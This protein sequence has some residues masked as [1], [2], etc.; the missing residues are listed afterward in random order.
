MNLRLAEE[1]EI[2][3]RR[4]YPLLYLVKKPDSREEKENIVHSNSGLFYIFIIVILFTCLGIL[5]NIGLKIQGINYQK[6]IYEINEMISLEE[7]RS[8]RLLLKISELKS[9]SRIIEAAKND[10]NMDMAGDFKIVEISDSGLENSEKIYN[11]ISKNT[12][13]V[14]KNYDSFLG[15]IYYIQ[16]IVL[17]VSESVLTFF[18]P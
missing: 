10:L 7:E 16:D 14:V 5:L 9:P 1:Q 6:S 15:T 3:K 13:T 2:Y 17:V 12:P 8:D 11:Y 4:S 18:I